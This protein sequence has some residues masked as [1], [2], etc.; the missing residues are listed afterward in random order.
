MKIGIIGLPNV[1]KSTL[2]NALT[3]AG[4]DSANY[5]LPYDIYDVSNNPKDIVNLTSVVLWDILLDYGY[6]ALCNRVPERLYLREDIVYEF[7]GEIN[8][9]ILD[10]YSNYKSYPEILQICKL[11]EV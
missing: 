8:P 4:V 11:C 5:P 7:S 3:S 1:G 2:F 9:G 10:M 6:I